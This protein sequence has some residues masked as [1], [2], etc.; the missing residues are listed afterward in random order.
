MYACMLPIRPSVRPSVHPFPRKFFRAKQPGA[1]PTRRFDMIVVVVSL[2]SLGMTNLPGAG[3]LRLLR[4]FRVFRLFKRIPS[5]RQI[6]V[7]ITSSVPAVTSAFVL[8]CLISAIYSIVAVTFFKTGDPEMFGDFFTGQ[9]PPA[10]RPRPP[11][12]PNGCGSRAGSLAL[13]A[14]PMKV[15]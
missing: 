6:M 1:A 11:P 12:P 2:L 10:A 5:L 15:L 9:P 3:P 13:I 4:C 14:G 7:A 8:V